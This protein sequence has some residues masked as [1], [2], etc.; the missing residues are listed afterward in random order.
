ME[1][2]MYMSQGAVNGRKS[3]RARHV[4]QLEHERRFGRIMAALMLLSGC[5][6]GSGITLMVMGVI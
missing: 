3:S 2:I 4:E 1:K 5:L 6:I